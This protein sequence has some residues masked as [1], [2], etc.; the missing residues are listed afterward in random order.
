[1]ADPHPPV[2][3][4]HPER[5]AGN[6]SSESAGAPPHNV[7]RQTTPHAEDQRD[8]IPRAALGSSTHPFISNF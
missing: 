2:T 3:G 8:G 1:M 4:R 7:S 6:P 5:G